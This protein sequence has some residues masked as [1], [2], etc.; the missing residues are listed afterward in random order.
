MKSYPKPP[1]ELIEDILKALSNNYAKFESFYKQEVILKD[2]I[3]D[4]LT[5]DLKETQQKLKKALE[6]PDDGMSSYE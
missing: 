6:T 3:I 5:T 1:I 4:K 2:S